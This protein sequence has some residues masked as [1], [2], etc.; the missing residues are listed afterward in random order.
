MISEFIE[1]NGIYRPFL[2]GKLCFLEVGKVYD[3]V[4][5]PFSAPC[6]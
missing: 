1:N 2:K 5:P 4:R 3:V 6:L